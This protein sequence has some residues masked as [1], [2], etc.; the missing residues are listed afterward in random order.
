MVKSLHFSK[1]Q[2]L[3]ND[4]VVIDAIHQQVS[5]SLQALRHIADRHYGIGCD[6]ILL[7]LPSARAD[8][9]YQ[10]FNA[11]GSESGQ[12]VNGARCV[13]LFAYEKGIVQQKKLTVETKYGIVEMQMLD[14]KNVQVRL[15]APLFDHASFM[16]SNLEKPLD[17]GEAFSSSLFYTVF[18][19][20]PH[21]VIWDAPQDEALYECVGRYCNEWHAAFP[22]GVNVNFIQKQAENALFLRVY[23]RGVGLTRAC[24]S[25]ACA[26]A[27]T[28]IL[29]QGF[30]TPLCVEQPGGVVSV[31]W[32]QGKQIVLTGIAEKVFEGTI[33]L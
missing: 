31:A 2:A 26:A 22:E 18:I 14:E 13:A 4:F 27:V 16:R 29:A 25:G 6:Q 20:N 5:L 23:E 24:G 17:L 12:C 10:I 15:A 19:G 8:F 30:S 33:A 32:Q 7:L 3:G 9:Y 1:M 11:D 28:A 21:L